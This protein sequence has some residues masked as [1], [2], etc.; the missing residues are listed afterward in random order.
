MA[1]RAP[2]GR[3]IDF[4][5]SR[6]LATGSNRSRCDRDRILLRPIPQPEW[7]HR[8]VDQRRFLGIP[9]FNDIVSDFP[10]ES[11]GLWA[12]RSCCVLMTGRIE[13]T[14]STNASVGRTT[15]YSLDSSLLRFGSSYDHRNPRLIRD[16]LLM[17]VSI[18]LLAAIVAER[19]GL[20]AV[21]WLM[22]LLLF[23]GVS[24]VWHWRV[25]EL[26]GARDLCLYTPY[27]CTQS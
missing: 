18:S 16:R 20:R 10:F 8:F 21:L 6:C 17:I 26:R 7:Y 4:T 13:D 5:K 24:S 27:S 3:R 2:R 1:G 9:N 19:I 23:I 25:S 11:V 22:P 14:S 12:L 15:S